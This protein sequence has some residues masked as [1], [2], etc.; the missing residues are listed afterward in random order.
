MDNLK[1]SGELWARI[2]PLLPVVNADTVGRDDGESMTVP[3]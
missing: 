1:V 2:Q 3:A